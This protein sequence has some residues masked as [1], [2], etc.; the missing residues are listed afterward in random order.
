[1]RTAQLC[2]GLGITIRGTERRA[3]KLGVTQLQRISEPS[4]PGRHAIGVP[5]PIRLRG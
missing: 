2:G 1:M 3:G 4:L 5:A